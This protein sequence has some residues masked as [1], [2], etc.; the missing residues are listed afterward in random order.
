MTCT[1]RN[2]SIQ[3][4]TYY[5]VVSDVSKN[6]YSSKICCGE[7]RA[8]HVVYIVPEAKFQAEKRFY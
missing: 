3:S 7:Y 5:T 8:R 1:K 6:C 4:E 2:R